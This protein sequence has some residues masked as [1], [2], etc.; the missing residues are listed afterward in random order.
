MREFQNVGDGLKK[1]IFQF[2]GPKQQARMDRSVLE[3]WESLFYEEMLNL[4][5]L[6]CKVFLIF[7]VY[8]GNF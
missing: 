6:N 7:I 5:I 8:S 4:R 2:P 1:E 3:A